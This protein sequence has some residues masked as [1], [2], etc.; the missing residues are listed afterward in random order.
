MLIPPAWLKQSLRWAAG[1]ALVLGFGGFFYG[2]Y[3][4]TRSFGLSLYAALIK[5]LQLYVLNV[6]P[7]EMPNHAVRVAGVLAPYATA[8][9]ILYALWYQASNHIAALRLRWRPATDLILG[10]GDT[11]AALMRK[12][13]AGA[14]G[15][16][17]IALIDRH[18]ET[19]VR[20][21]VGA[22]NSSADRAM[23]LLALHGDMRSADLHR[24]TQ[25]L[26]A[27][28]IWIMSG[29]DK[30][31]L[32]CARQLMA[33]WNEKSVHARPELFIRLRDERL[34][35][36]EQPPRIGGEN[37]WQIEYIDLPKIALRVLW[38]KFPP[39]LP[40]RMTERFELTRQPH[41][42]VIGDARF[43][44][45][46]AL[47]ATRHWVLDEAPAHC[48]AITF[49]GLG[50][51]QCRQQLLQRAPLLNADVTQPPSVAPL[52]PLATINS[53]TVDAA[54]ID[55]A[56]WLNAQRDA[57]FDA[58]YI[59]CDDDAETLL[60]AARANT[61][62]RVFGRDTENDSAPVPVVACLRQPDA[63]SAT[64]SAGEAFHRFTVFEQGIKPFTH[65]PGDEDDLVAQRIN[66]LF[67]SD[68]YDAND[69]QLEQAINSFWR[70][71][72]ANEF[73]WSSRYAADHMEVKKTLLENYYGQQP[74]AMSDAA[75]QGLMQLEHR[76]F[77]VERLLDGW[78]P[79]TAEQMQGQSKQAL[80][81]QRLNPTLVPFDQLDIANARKDEVIVRTLAWITDTDTG[82]A[83]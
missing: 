20:G 75:I 8:S 58:V 47:H 52:L 13:K 29:D 4:E 31:N 12:K 70:E 21:A 40:P 35:R 55:P 76:R 34:A 57:A 37:I 11:A 41:I 30:L 53:C 39:R 50:A 81:A 60:A 82:K 5:T 63:A 49:F 14:D 3:G 68:K 54:D 15:V 71:R 64:S 16:P 19:A 69:P 22:G 48:L 66:Y 46:L 18:S 45:T 28:R 36:A 79:V 38:E 78:L 25:A 7:H 26:R 10:G 2:E 24:L 72:T 44:Q 80:R 32:H 77:V 74:A 56:S 62:C 59:C 73:R 65:Y 9:V 43:A 61:L 6:A 42:A 17:R 67:G 51:E 23:Q 83:T 1:G 33:A 27:R